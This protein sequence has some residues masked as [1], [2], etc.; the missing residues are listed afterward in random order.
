[1]SVDEDMLGR[2][3]GTPNQEWCK[4]IR[5]ARMTGWMIPWRRLGPF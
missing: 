4:E 2:G 3:L 5:E 1:M